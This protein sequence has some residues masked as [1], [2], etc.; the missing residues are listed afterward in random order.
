PIECSRPHG[1]LR[2]LPRQV[3]S[4][5]FPLTSSP[6]LATLAWPRP[7]YALIPLPQASARC[8]TLKGTSLPALEVSQ[9]FRMST[10]P[11]R[12]PRTNPATRR[13]SDSPLLKWDELR[14]FLDPK[15]LARPIGQRFVVYAD[16]RG[17]DHPDAVDAIQ[18]TFDKLLALLE[19]GR[20]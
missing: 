1:H 3:P 16:E 19:A 14:A 4:E 5:S 7:R 9:R 13:A 17:V 15:G 2:G 8:A 6:A 12:T 10:K 11:N 20:A 18:K